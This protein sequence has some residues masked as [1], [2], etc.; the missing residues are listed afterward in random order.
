MAGFAEHGAVVAEGGRVGGVYPLAEALVVGAVPD[1]FQAFAVEVADAGAGRRA[2][3]DVAVAEHDAGVPG[4]LAPGVAGLRE[5]GGEAGAGLDLHIESGADFPGGFEGAVPKLR[6]VGNGFFRHVGRD[7]PEEVQPDF[8]GA[9]FRRA[10]HELGNF[11]DVGAHH[12]H[13]EAD[14][15][16]A[17]RGAVTGHGAGGVEHGGELTTAAAEF[18]V[19]GLGG[20]IA[21][22]ADAQDLAAQ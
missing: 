12:D 18:G 4:F 6:F 20:G 22:K 2:G 5:I 16:S 1:V 8:V 7:H 11:A 17:R 9:D 15:G 14:D 21:G 3:E 10:F 13:R 19:G